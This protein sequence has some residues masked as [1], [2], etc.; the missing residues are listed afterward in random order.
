M[1]Q[2]LPMSI[3][4]MFAD[5][6]SEPFLLAAVGVALILTGSLFVGGRRETTQEPSVARTV[7]RRQIP[8]QFRAI[9]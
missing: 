2:L 8:R 7:T 6:L 3:F 4:Q 9:E 5:V 1:S